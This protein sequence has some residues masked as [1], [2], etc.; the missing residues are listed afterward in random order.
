MKVVKRF[1]IAFVMCMSLMLVVPGILTDNSYGISTVEAAGKV[2]INKNKAYVSKGDTV[3]LSVSGTSKKVKW[4]TSS[5]K[6]ATVSS[7]GVVKGIKKGNATITAKVA[8]K[9]YKCKVTVELPS[10]SK[11]KVSLNAGSSTTLKVKNTKQK[12]SWKS[13]NKRVATVTSKGVVKGIKKGTATITAKIGN[14]RLTCKVTVK[15]S[16]AKKITYIGDRD[17]DYDDKTQSHRIFFSLILSDGVTRVSSSGTI[18]VMI[19]NNAEETVFNRTIAFN[20]NNFDYWT[21]E[22]TGEECL[23]CC[24]YIPD[25]VITRGSVSTGKIGYRINLSQGLQSKLYIDDI[26]S[27]PQG[28]AAA[29]NLYALKNYILENG[30]TNSNG[31]YIISWIDEELGITHGIIYESAENRFRFVCRRVSSDSTTSLQMYLDLDNTGFADTILTFIAEEAGLGFQAT[32]D[33]YIPGYDPDRQVDFTLE[34]A[35]EGLT[36]SSIQGTANAS[37]RGAFG[38]WNYILLR[39]MG[40]SLTDIGFLSY[41]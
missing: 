13:S 17:V 24:I 36:E 27:L 1:C 34:M 30:G 15:Q 20:K 35:T 37:L 39:D 28:N 32:A 29:D 26:D 3:K 10:I 38:G 14:K 8:G 33:I 21:Y 22:A 31:E 18:E 2:K 5:K 23:L 6:I 19:M 4:S 9:K 7:K 40:F 16:A 41:E 11:K 25:S 12:V